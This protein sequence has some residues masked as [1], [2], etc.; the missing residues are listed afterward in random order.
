M[1]HDRVGVFSSQNYQITFVSP[2]LKP[3]H[4]LGVASFST[5]W[6]SMYI[7]ASQRM[8]DEWV[9]RPINVKMWGQYKCW[10]ISCRT[11]KP[12]IFNPNY[13][14]SLILRVLWSV[15]IRGLTPHTSCVY[16]D[17]CSPPA[18]YS[19]HLEWIQRVFTKHPLRKCGRQFQRSSTVSKTMKIKRS[20]PRMRW[21]QWSSSLRPTLLLSNF[22]SGIIFPLLGIVYIKFFLKRA[23]LM[24]TYTITTTTSTASSFRSIRVLTYTSYFKLSSKTPLRTLSPSSKIHF[25]LLLVI[26]VVVPTARERLFW[27][28]KRGRFL[29]LL[30]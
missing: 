12:A 25:A 28:K 14:S 21:I 3:P 7:R 11:Y 23:E 10:D 4:R 2:S 26:N 30:W 19:G 24:D 1:P 22:V 6:F 15:K 20:L 18:L 17:E 27:V 8:H 13:S 9:G 16:T 5:L 29:I